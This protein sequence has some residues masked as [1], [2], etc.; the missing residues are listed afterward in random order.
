VTQWSPLRLR[1]RVLRCIVGAVLCRTLLVSGCAGHGVGGDVRAGA[2]GGATTG[3][4]T[5]AGGVSGAC[6]TFG[7]G[8]VPVGEGLVVEAGGAGAPR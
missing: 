3:G 7:V 4:A 2:F 6:A 5:T 8:E 1:R